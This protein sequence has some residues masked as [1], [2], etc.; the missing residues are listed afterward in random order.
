MVL[1]RRPVHNSDTAAPPPKVVCDEKEVITHEDVSRISRKAP[2]LLKPRQTLADLFGP[3]QKNFN[4]PSDYAQYRKRLRQAL[5]T[6][7]TQEKLEIVRQ[8][9]AKGAF[10]EVSTLPVLRSDLLLQR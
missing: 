3:E 8:E 1:R 9:K 6:M 2:S 5:A 4:E 10:R 7:N